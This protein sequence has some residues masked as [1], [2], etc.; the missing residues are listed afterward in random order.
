MSAHH[1]VIEAPHSGDI[2]ALV[3]LFKADLLDL[4]LP[5]PE[6]ALTQTAAQLIEDNGDRC[7]LRVA[8]PRPGAP[9]AGVIVAHRWTSVKFAGAA[10]WLE[11]L[12]VDKS[13]RRCGM[14]RKL[15]C[16]LIDDATE[17]GFS[18][19]DLESY[20]MNAPA[21]FLYRS[22]GFRRLGRE[23]YSKRLRDT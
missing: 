6:N 21:S 9:A 20:R 10:W 7:W 11:T 2:I 23:R 16:A 1:A 5:I 8:R 13:L 22:L 17:R 18:G 4:N 15:V 19:I 3:E 12:Y 14:G